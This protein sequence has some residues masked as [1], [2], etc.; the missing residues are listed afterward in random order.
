MSLAVHFQMLARYNR[1]ANERIF[2]RCVKLD[3]VEYRRTRSGSFGSIHHLLNHVLLG[4]QIWMDRFQG[5]APKTPRLDMI[6]AE[7]FP[8]LRSARHMQDTQIE[9]FFARLHDDFFS[10]SFS[11]TN[12]RGLNYVESAPVAVSHFFNHQ[13]HHRGQVHVMLSQAQVA[14]PSLDLHRIINP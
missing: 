3:D 2:D 4:D 14:P 13:T 8:E 9:E 5:G 11:Y 10:R 1:I 12:H 7:S 6:L